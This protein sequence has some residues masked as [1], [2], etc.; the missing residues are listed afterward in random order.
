MSIPMEEAAAP[1]LSPT[2]PPAAVRLELTML[3]EELRNVQTHDKGER[4]LMLMTLP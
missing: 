4:R 3:A 1:M 2:A